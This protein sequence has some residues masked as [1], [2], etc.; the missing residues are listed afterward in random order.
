MGDCVELYLPGRN[1]M[2]EA[3][4]RAVRNP[5][6]QAA[7]FVLEQ[8]E[9]ISLRRSGGSF[10]I[11]CVTGWLWATVDKSAEDYV[12]APGQ[13]R[14]FRGRG[15]AVIQALR[16]ASVRVDCDPGKS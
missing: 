7:T 1:G 5:A 8:G 9:V 11:T 4:L 10:R 12:L 2:S 6:V 16:T 15:T 14:S 13:A 3:L